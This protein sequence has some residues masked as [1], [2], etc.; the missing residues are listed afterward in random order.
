MSRHVTKRSVRHRSRGNRW[1]RGLL[2]QPGAAALLAAVALAGTACT[3]ALPA[4]NAAPASPG[5]PAPPAQLDGPYPVTRVVDG[6]T[7]WISRGGTDEKL[8]LIGVDTPE[9]HDPRTPVQCYAQ[10]A[11]DYTKSLHG[12]QIY[13][14]TDP[15]QDSIDRYGRTLAYVWTGDRHLINYELIAAGYAHEYTYNTPYRY[16]TTFQ[17][18]EDHARTASVGLWSPANCPAA[19]PTGR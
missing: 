8:R 19:A 1:G 15:S 2:P 14:E 11:S 9:L 7:L 6:D 5:A 18:A 17:A 13:L 12:Q 4:I 10:Q 16:Q 3:T